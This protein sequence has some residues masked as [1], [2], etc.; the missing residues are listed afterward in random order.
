LGIELTCIGVKADLDLFHGGI[1]VDRVDGSTLDVSSGVGREEIGALLDH[2]RLGIC[3]GGIEGEVTG[4]GVVNINGSGLVTGANE[5]LDGAHHTVLG[6]GL[7]LHGSPVGS[8]PK[9]DEGFDGTSIGVNTN[10]DNLLVGVGEL[11]MFTRGTLDTYRAADGAEV[12]FG[13]HGVEG[14]GFGN[15]LVD[16]EAVGRGGAEGNEGGGELHG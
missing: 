7:N 9:L 6:V 11:P 4:S 15:G 10:L 12:P 13:G 5:G 3:G 2:G 1:E 14:R 8:D 16:G